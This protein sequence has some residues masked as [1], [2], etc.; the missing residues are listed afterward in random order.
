MVPIY[1][2]TN[3]TTETATL[4][5]YQCLDLKSAADVFFQ[6]MGHKNGVDTW[7]NLV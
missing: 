4:I 5:V 1:Y 6:E 7:K 3:D 2:K